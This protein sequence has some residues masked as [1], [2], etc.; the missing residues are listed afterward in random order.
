M[1]SEGLFSLRQIKMTILC[2]LGLLFIGSNLLNGASLD[3]L[4]FDGNVL[5]TGS[6]TLAQRDDLIQFGGLGSGEAIGSPNDNLFDLAFFEGVASPNYREVMRIHG[7]N[8]GIGTKSPQQNLSI[9]G[10]LNVD[11]A[12]ANDGSAL[13]PGLSFG[14]LSGE[15]IASK[16]TSGGNQFGLDLYT[17]FLNRLSITNAGN[18]G[19]GTSDPGARLHILNGDVAI[20]GDNSSLQVGFDPNGSSLGKGNMLV[21][22]DVLIGGNTSSDPFVPNTPL[23]IRA[24]SFISDSGGGFLPGLII[25]SLGV[26]ASLASDALSLTSFDNGTS[27]VNF[28]ISPSNRAAFIQW[29]GASKAMTI[30]TLGACSSFP[31]GENAF[32]RSDPITFETAEKCVAD[33]NDPLSTCPTV[34][35]IVERM[36][37]AGDE[38]LISGDVKARNFFG[39][40]HDL[41]CINC[42][43]LNEMANDS[44]DSRSIV[45]GAVTSSKIL[46]GTIDT[47][48]LNDASVTMRKLALDSVSSGQIQDGSINLQDLAP[49]LCLPSGE[50]MVGWASSGL[51]CLNLENAVKVIGGWNRDGTNG[52]TLENLGDKVGIGTN[53]PNSTLQIKGDSGNP[54]YLQID[55]IDGRPNAD[56][57]NDASEIG[58]MVLDFD[59]NRLYVCSGRPTAIGWRFTV[60]QSN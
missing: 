41:S 32:C 29:D 23:Y 51:R 21:S 20:S 43:D 24:L 6:L 14:S 60:L 11:Q 8:V 5:V 22:G 27:S 53:N 12:D 48:D 46:D 54:G 25:D 33:P 18:I 10:A 19:I 36:R 39:V 45:D 4:K 42:V 56:D 47:I 3:L 50:V 1:F 26:E 52:V 2:I 35:T 7:G 57:C 17:S 16:R 38:I 31:R 28:S 34:P 49:Q 9:N 15:G 13:N 58:R 40:S 59:N 30:E 37:I 44:V 55:S